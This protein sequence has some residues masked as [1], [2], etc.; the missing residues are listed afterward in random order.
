MR[1]RL[2]TLILVFALSALT[3]FGQGP[4]KST[5]RPGLTT[6]ESQ[7]MELV[8]GT[9]I[10]NHDLELEQIAY[11]HT[12]SN[13]SFRAAGSS[14]ANATAD[15]LLEQFNLLGLEAHKEPFQF[16]TW[17][18]A[19]KPILIVDDDGN[20][21]TAA[22]QMNIAPF[23][24]EHYSWPTSSDGVFADLVV[25]PLPAAASYSE[26]GA[27][28]INMTEWNS[29]NTTGKILLTGREI[30][31]ADSWQTTYRN[32]LAA[33][34]PA[35]VVYTWWYDWDSFQPDFFSS[36]GGRPLAGPLGPYYWNLHIPVGFTDY[37][38]GLWIRN[39][40][41]SLNVSAQVKVE[42]TIGS[43]L[44]YNVVARLNGTR[45]PDKTVIV[46][47][48]YDT[49][50]SSG[51]C[52]NGAGTAGVL[53]LARVFV[54]TNRSGLFRPKYT[55]LFIAFT[56]EELS[57][58]GSTNYIMQHKA[59]MSNIVAV[60][61][62]DCIG[63]D[64]LYVSETN[65]GPEFDLDQLILEA[66]QDLDV[67]GQTEAPGGSDQETFRDPT[68]ANFQYSYYWSLNAG[69]SDATPVQSSAMIISYPLTP[70][71]E[72]STGDPGWIHTSYDNSTS[73]TTLN[74]VETDDL[75]NHV[76]VAALSI[77]RIT[78][79]LI[80]DINDDYV[81]DMKD[82]SYVARRFGIN[83]TS[84]L[85]DPNADVVSDG[86]IDMKDIGTVAKHFGETGP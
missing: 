67:P 44:H 55:I 2:F 17:D 82:I 47:S 43:G 24:C 62:L 28:S 40:E 12:L 72:F 15:W 13:Y 29:I 51:F 86:K 16:T 42:A 38:A 49:I 69:I 34:P 83:A 7:I 1:K 77:S 65:Q 5:L 80:G 26:I 27:R 35:A 46:S 50:M 8:N 74:W 6:T 78:A 64:N 9:N 30:R 84:P 71:E 39:R 18:V 79:T 41:S 31:W 73:T 70:T 61:N 36:T 45:Y 22:D 81:V 58:V 4:T 23:Q 10:Y 85:W 68:A 3:L 59:E 37:G 76:R 11:N 54:E 63:S 32:K 14:G 56:G 60:I 75:A 25:L 20:P 48:H 57:L 33:Q 52:D 19:S 21:S 53:E 66:G